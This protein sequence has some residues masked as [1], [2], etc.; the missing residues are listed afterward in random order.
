MKQ[1]TAIFFSLFALPVVLLSVSAF[2]QADIGARQAT[3]NFKKDALA[4]TAAIEQFNG[5]VK[6]MDDPAGIA[7]AKARLLDCRLAFK[8]IAYF[9]AYFFPSETKMYN[10]PAKYEVEEPEL[11][12]EEPMGL[13]Q[14][15]ALLFADDALMN[16]AAL[17][18][19]TDALYTSA[20]DLP[21]LL[22]GFKANDRQVLESL[23][24][25]L[26]RMATLYI[27]GYDAPL[28]K[29]GIAE[30]LEASRIMRRTLALYL[31]SPED[32]TLAATLQAAIDYL[33]AHPDFDG[34]DRLTYLTRF[35][36]PLQQQLGAFISSRHLELNTTAYLNYE[37]INSFRPGFLRRW[38]SIPELQRASLAALGKR[39]FFDP[40]LSGNMRV[41][42]GSCH[43]PEKYFTDG[44]F[45]SPSL[46]HGSGL[47]RNT[48]TLLYSGFQHS[49]FWDGRA[50]DLVS[51]IKD[52]LNNPLEMGNALVS[53]QKNVMESPRYRNDFKTRDKFARLTRALAA[54]VS[55]LSPMN[56]A[57]DRYISGNHRAM[58]TAQIRGFNL[59][60]GKAQCGTCHFAPYFNSLT[61]P[62]YDVS[63]TE[64]LGTPRTDQ[65]EKPQ[66]DPDAGRYD[67]Y[68]VSNYRQ[69]FKTP[70]LRNVQRTGPYMHNGA[71]KTL[72]SVL[73]FYNK[74]GGNGIG[75]NNKE[76]TLPA[77]PLKLSDTEIEQIIQFMN[78]LTDEHAY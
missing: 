74:G 37:A 3:V 71:F 57:F 35:N 61:P 26:I 38:D 75:L 22:F 2:E 29:S 50:P 66:T 24:L 11:E 41:S 67:L 73:D 19:Q 69:A 72:K 28:L 52:V 27:S 40:A 43:Q 45:R 25:E 56:S 46:V 47:K 42:C 76:Q 53:L 23:R 21:A 16:R 4:F 30:T 44:R 62:L 36:L 48:P 77:Q 59:F 54:Y 6:A 33:A 49:Q 14:I 8:Q 9:T 63:E 31:R 32:D 64:I 1:K 12:L 10:G 20:K 17:L 58:T 78:T 39:L 34:F 18:V 13:Q 68:P 65:L 60:M 5:A 7:R 15:E 55:S 51:Q 70:T